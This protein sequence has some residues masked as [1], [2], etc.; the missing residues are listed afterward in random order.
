M[1]DLVFLRLQII[2]FKKDAS[3]DLKSQIFCALDI[4]LADQWGKHNVTESIFFQI[5]GIIRHGDKT[6]R[7]VYY[8]NVSVKMKILFQ[9]ILLLNK[10]T[11]IYVAHPIINTNSYYDLIATISSHQI[12]RILASSIFSR[13]GKLDFV[14]K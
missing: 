8:V 7:L 4:R 2:Y 5:L 11:K 1:F 6:Y 14:Y 3:N 10:A 9:L 13:R 12:H